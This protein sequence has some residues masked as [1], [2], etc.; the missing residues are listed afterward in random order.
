MPKITKRIKFSGNGFFIRLI[1]ICNRIFFYKACRLSVRVDFTKRIAYYPCDAKMSCWNLINI[2]LRCWR[3]I[4]ENS[5]NGAGVQRA[6]RQEKF[7]KARDSKS[8]HPETTIILSIKLVY[9]FEYSFKENHHAE[10]GPETLTKFLNN[11]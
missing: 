11:L 4:K 5:R 3:K 1:E 6:C 2:L 7:P 10:I 9:R 8:Q